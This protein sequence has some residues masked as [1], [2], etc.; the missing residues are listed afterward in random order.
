MQQ[1]LLLTFMDMIMITIVVTY[2]NVA[3]ITK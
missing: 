3:E 2:K 1:R